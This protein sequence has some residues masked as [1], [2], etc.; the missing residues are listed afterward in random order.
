MIQPNYYKGWDVWGEWQLDM[1]EPARGN[2]V[3]MNIMTI[4]R[5]E[6]TPDVYLKGM[7]ECRETRADARRGEGESVMNMSAPY[8]RISA[9]AGGTVYSGGSSMMPRT[10]PMWTVTSYRMARN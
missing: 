2:A 3:R 7:A 5:Y 10:A 9:E 1:G 4:K 6:K 8:C